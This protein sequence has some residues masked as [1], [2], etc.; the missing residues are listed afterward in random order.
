MR[1]V[2]SRLLLANVTGVIVWLISKLF[3]VDLTPEQ[4]ATLNELLAAGAVVVNSAIVLLSVLMG[5]KA[6]E[7]ALPVNKESGHTNLLL[8]PFLCGVVLS[9][10]AACSLTPQETVAGGYLAVE[11]TARIVKQ[12]RVDGYIS[13]DTAIAL[14]K[15]LFKAVDELDAAASFLA[16]DDV[17]DQD[18]AHVARARALLTGVKEFI[19]RRKEMENVSE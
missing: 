6:R 11:E 2:E 17:T 5:K 18:L 15:Q 19:E 9:V 16:S 14:Q 7:E 1:S 12:A 3:G 4:I 8:L 13:K 10:I